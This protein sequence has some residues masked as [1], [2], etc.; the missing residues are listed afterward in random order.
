MPG[1]RQAPVERRRP[2]LRRLDACAAVLPERWLTPRRSAGARAPVARE[3][4][5]PGIPCRPTDDGRSLVGKASRVL[6][7]PSD[8]TDPMDELSPEEI[9]ALLASLPE[10]AVSVTYD[11]D[12]NLTYV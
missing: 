3:H 2:S 7:M 8:E 5:E 12:T 4:P 1:R 9:Q 10:P 6:H 11:L